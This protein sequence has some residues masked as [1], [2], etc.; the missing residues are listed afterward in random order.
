[1]ANKGIFRR[2]NYLKLKKN[3]LLE[4]KLNY[5]NICLERTRAA[6]KSLSKTHHML[7][8]EWVEG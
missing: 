2:K 3:L 4:I 5:I 1:M 6:M 8:T 7:A